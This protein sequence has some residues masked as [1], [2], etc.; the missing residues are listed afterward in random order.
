LIALGANPNIQDRRPRGFGRS[1]GWT[2][3]FVALHHDQFHSAAALLER[4]AD[5]SIRS[6]QGMSVMEIA[7]A[8]GAP[9]PLRDLMV[10][11]GFKNK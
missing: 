2:P 11:K 5:P 8:E 7:S 4:G 10:A 9:Q 6:D 1:S 3:L